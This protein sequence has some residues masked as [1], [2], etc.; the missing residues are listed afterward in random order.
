[1]TDHI[2][3]L[4]RKYRGKGILLDTNILLLYLVGSIDPQNVSSFKR[5]SGFDENDF[6]IL[7]NLV[8]LFERNVTTPHILAEASNFLNAEKYGALAAFINHAGEKFVEGADIVAKSQFSY[9]GITDTAV[10]AIAKA[11]VLVVT[12]DGPLLGSLTADGIDAINFDDVRKA[13]L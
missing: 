2:A 4:I 12:N 9:L 6:Y 3:D 10:L 5:T 8:N 11:S 13:F 7:S 1:M